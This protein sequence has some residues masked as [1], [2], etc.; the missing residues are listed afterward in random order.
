MN[1]ADVRDQLQNC[2]D[3]LQTIKALL[4]GMGDNA[5]P[6]PYMKRYAV[7]R[8]TGTIESGFKQI[9]ADRVDRDSHEQLRNFIARKIRKSSSNP[10]LGVITNMLEEFDSVWRSRFEEQIALADQPTLKGALTELVT[11]RNSFA[12]GGAPD[13]PIDRTIECFECG[14]TVLRLLDQTVHEVNEPAGG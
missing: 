2:R 3:E 4:T 8:A 10:S 1:N 5:N 9:I 7:I 14:C 13:L 11:A 12:H 6:T